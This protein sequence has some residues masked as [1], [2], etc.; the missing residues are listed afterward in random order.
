[1]KFKSDIR[2]R[3]SLIWIVIMINMIYND[4]FSIVVEIVEKGSFA[5]IPGEVKLVMAI[6]G[7]VTI[8]LL[9]L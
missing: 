3:L 5:E 8:L 9:M 4:I 6:A 1:M 7:I 2:T